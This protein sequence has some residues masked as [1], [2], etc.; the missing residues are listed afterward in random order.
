MKTVLASLSERTQDRG[1]P[2]RSQVQ[3]HHLRGDTGFIADLNWNVMRYSNIPAKQI[4]R[5]HIE[6]NKESEKYC[7]IVEFNVFKL[8]QQ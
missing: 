1:S 6:L 4:P 2:N 8:I 5:N 7:K 3:N